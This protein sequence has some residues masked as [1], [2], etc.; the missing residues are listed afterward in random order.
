MTEPINNRFV[1]IDFDKAR[2]ILEEE[3]DEARA[4]KTK[5]PWVD[6]ARALSEECKDKHRTMIAMLGTALLA[7][8]TEI[9]VDVFS[10]RVGDDQD[11][12]TY[13]AR[14]LCKE[15][16]A[17]EAPRLG[18]D[19]GV[20]GREPLNNQPFFGKPRVSRKMNVRAD[21][22]SALACLCDAL[23]ALDKVRTEREARTALRSFI[24]VRERKRSVI[25]VEEGEGDNLTESDLAALID[26]FVSED[27]EGGKRAQ[28]VAAGLLD[29]MQG[30]ERVRASRVNDPSRRM[31]G[32]VGLLS[33]RGADFERVFEVRDKP[34][35]E[36]DLNSLIDR[37][38]GAAVTKVGMLAVSRRQKP[39][40]P[41]RAISR[42][43][44]RSIRLGVYFGWT[45]FV[46]EVLFW[47]KLPC[48]SVGPAY[49]AIA[50]RLAELEVSPTGLNRW[51]K[52]VRG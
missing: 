42:G 50:V 28:A 9:K 24:Q 22:E 47:S 14:A 5:G 52:A 11:S 7:K 30:K 32:D 10:L 46:K 40:D 20:S 16:L 12:N 44:S 36:Q 48:L 21:A 2:R 18:I 25:E 17:A 23:E 43:E 31:P 13:S 38:R 45:D 33:D 1:K 8:A 35:T 3:T 34:I 29:A 41:A 37:I 19:L 15:V 26:D 49:R 39:L 51:K 4:I 27:S 6:R